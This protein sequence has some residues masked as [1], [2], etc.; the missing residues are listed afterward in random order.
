MSR[1]GGRQH[2]N[3]P[4]RLSGYCIEN[5]IKHFIPRRWCVTGFLWGYRTP[6]DIHRK[7]L[8]LQPSSLL[9][10]L[11][12]PSLLPL[13]W[14][15]ESDWRN[16]CQGKLLIYAQR[17]GEMLAIAL[18]EPLKI[19]R[20]ICINSHI[21]LEPRCLF[22]TPVLDGHLWGSARNNRLYQPCSLLLRGLVAIEHFY[23]LASSL[24]PGTHT[25]HV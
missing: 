9:G 16:I 11:L 10:L 14:E 22:A 19:R 18:H 23:I 1:K 20:N 6:L 5:F 24:V 7:E 3:T 2:T 25:G 15:W 17:A 12:Q 21:N 8:D 4:T 13:M